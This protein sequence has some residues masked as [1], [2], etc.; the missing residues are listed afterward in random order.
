MIRIIDN[1]KV[2]ITDDEFKIYNNLCKSYEVHGGSVLFE[3]LFESDDNGII[4]FIKPPSKNFI[5]YEITF[6]II[7]I[8]QHQH[9]RIMY[10]TI[11]ELSNKVDQKMM[12]LDEKIK[13]LD[14][15]LK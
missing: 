1:K 3:D 7:S 4:L 10:N 6:F 13:L 15:K 12:L 2:D 11:K 5:S 14:E 8:F 9:T